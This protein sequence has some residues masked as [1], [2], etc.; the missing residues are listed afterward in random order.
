MKIITA[1]LLTAVALGA[2]SAQAAEAQRSRFGALKDGTAVDSVTLSNSSGVKARVVAWG[3]M[4]QSLVVPDRHGKG[5]DIVLSYPDM[6]GYQEKPQ[7]FGATVGRFANRIAG[8]AFTL[9]G[10]KYTLA[11]ND[12]ANTLHGGV[13][14]FDKQ[15]WTI[16]EVKSGP[17][18]SVTLTRTSPDGEEGYPGTLKVSVTYALDQQNRLT[19]TYAAT[20]DKPTVVNLS[21]HALFNLAGAASG[22]SV[23]DQ[24]LTI[25]ADGYTPVDAG[26]IPTGEIKPVAGTPFDF[27]TPHAIGERVSDGADPQLV[28]GRGYDHNWVL[29]GGVSKTPRLAVRYE[30]PKSG[31][32]MEILTTEPGIQ[33]YSGNFLD[34]TVVG[35]DHTI[36][37]QGDGIAL[38]PQHFPDSPN[39]PSFPNTR[40]DPG[41]TYR[42]VAIYRFSTTPR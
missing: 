25:V 33:F 23:M 42:H 32:V 26:L 12:G 41:Q 5:A 36:Y 15:L 40:L 8:A 27:R 10:Q 16:S 21:N 2:A 39:Q 31:R 34:A 1:G 11:K 14:G 29:K 13:H 28:I 18:A 35:V 20:T 9:D 37:R 3:A 38:E 6:T 17:L 7:F 24:R 22:R 4:L 19:V 30:D